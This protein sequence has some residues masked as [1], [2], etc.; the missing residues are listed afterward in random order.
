MGKRRAGRHGSPFYRRVRERA[1]QPLQ[2]EWGSSIRPS[3]P[4]SS[5]SPTARPKLIGVGHTHLKH[6]G[7]WSFFICSDRA[8]LAQT[9]YAIND[10]PL[11][12]RCWTSSTSGIA[13]K[14]A[15]AVRSACEPPIRKSRPAHRQARNNRTAQAQTARRELG[16]QGAA[17][18]SQPTAD[19]AH[20]PPHDHAQAQSA[21]KPAC[22]RH[23]RPRPHP[24]LYAPQGHPGRHP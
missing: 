23:R 11:C 9:L 19:P 8:K 4:Q 12:R 3:A 10:K 15:W 21:R 20:A 2:S 18:L 5:R 6:G 14:W 13:A 17:R 24:R 1:C 16:R 22:P 7:G